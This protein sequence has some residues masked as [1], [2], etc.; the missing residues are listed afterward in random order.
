MAPSRSQGP[1]SI[2]EFAFTLPGILGP[3]CMSLV[4]LG[5]HDKLDRPNVWRKHSLIL[6]RSKL[7]Q[8][9]LLLCHFSQLLSRLTDFWQDLMNI[10]IIHEGGVRTL[11]DAISP[12]AV[13]TKLP[14]QCSTG[15]RLL[16]FIAHHQIRGA[17]I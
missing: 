1:T 3:P 14:A 5:V 11:N 15:G 7:P 13:A 16:V 8:L 9:H 4:Y 10:I 17:S 12:R 2:H 6:S